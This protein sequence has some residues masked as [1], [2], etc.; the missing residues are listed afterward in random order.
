MAFQVHCASDRASTGELQ[1]DRLA[2]A[3]D[4]PYQAPDRRAGLRAVPQGELR[5]RV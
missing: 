1:T 3:G 5:A 2:G 4:E